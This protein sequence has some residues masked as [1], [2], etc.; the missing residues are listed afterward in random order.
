MFVIFQEL[1]VDTMKAV[2]SWPTTFSLV[3]ITRITMTLRKRDFLKKFLMVSN[4]TL[5]IVFAYLLVNVS[6]PAKLMAMKNASWTVKSPPCAFTLEYTEFKGETSFSNWRLWP[7][8][9]LRGVCVGV[10]GLF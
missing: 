6:G 4:I 5:S 1:I 3:C 8:R 7:K 10:T 9:E 2:G